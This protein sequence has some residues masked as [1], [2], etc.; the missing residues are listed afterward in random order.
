MK[1]LIL[2]IILL[3]PA[4]AGAQNREGEKMPALSLKDIKG[5][6][7]N[8][9]DYKGKVILLNFWATWCVP[10]RAEAPELVKWQN[11]YRKRGLQIVGV[12]YP[13]TDTVKVRGFARR[14]KINYP[15]LFGSKKTKELFD[16]GDTLP[17]S[18]VIDREGIIKALIEGVVFEDEFDEKIKP[19]LVPAS[20]TSTVQN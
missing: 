10:C 14:N 2:T 16:L 13:P 6:T 19:L 17:F 1:A 11:E 4:F 20:S 15:V 8:L 18:V 7:V 12:T 9:R 5:K 3:L